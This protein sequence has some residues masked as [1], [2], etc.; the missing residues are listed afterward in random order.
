M[1]RV[2]NRRPQVVHTHAIIDGAERPVCIAG[3]DHNSI[4][5]D[6]L[7]PHARMLETRGV[8]RIVELPAKKPAM[9][10]PENP[11]EVDEDHDHDHE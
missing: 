1:Y 6:D 10:V 5:V 4:V 3:G 7:H 8:L 11:P 2:T 9:T